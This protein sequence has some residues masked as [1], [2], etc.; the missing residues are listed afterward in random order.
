MADLV[1]GNERSEIIRA[2][3]TVF[4]AQLLQKKSLLP[5]EQEGQRIRQPGVALPTGGG[6][7]K[8][9]FQ[10]WKSISTVADIVGGNERSEIIRALWTVFAAQLLQ[11]KSLLPVEQEGQQMRVCLPVW[12][13]MTGGGGGR[14][15]AQKWKSISTVADI[16]GGNERSEIIRALWTV[17]AAQL[18][19][20]KSLLSVE[21][22][23]Q[24]I[25]QPGVALPTG[26]GGGKPTFQKWKSISTV[27][28]IVGGNERSEI[29]RALWTVFA[30]QLLQKKSLLSVE[31]EGQPIRVCLPVWPCM[32]GG[33]GGRPT[34]QKWKSISTMADIV[35][36][37]GR[38]EINWSL[39]TV[40]AAQL[41]QRLSRFG[42]NKKTNPGQR[43]ACCMGKGFLIQ[44]IP[45]WLPNHTYMLTVRGDG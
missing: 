8:P 22:E 41:L 28:D 11:K 40:L 4:A 27:A 25:R 1:G 37:N 31:Q 38:S 16:V 15:T 6:G 17:F 45:Q 39:W 24:R 18:L 30:A 10:K 3:W 21:Q 12:P 29:I 44:F 43:P 42:D 14:P 9:T 36:E 33:G 19:Q 7:G 32:T 20:K 13:S 34:V 23:G 26:G 2:L 5:V 35:V